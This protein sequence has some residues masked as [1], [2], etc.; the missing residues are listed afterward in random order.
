VRSIRTESICSHLCVSRHSI[1][2]VDLE[3][4]KSSV[5]WLVLTCALLAPM[6]CGSEQGQ[7]LFRP[8][9]DGA[10]GLEISIGAGG[11]GVG[12]TVGATRCSGV[13][14]QDICWHLAETGQSCT[15]AC[16]S[17][18]GTDSRA[19][20]IVG[21]TAQGGDQ[22]N[23]AA[24]LTLLGYRQTVTV[25][26]G[27]DCGCYLYGLGSASYWSSSPDFNPNASRAGARI[28]CGCSS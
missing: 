9:A 23:C 26:S 7:D 17:F 28:A 27:F 16:Q 6:G 8:P 10:G 19:P 12:G 20:G 22:L 14:Y 1:S 21:S 25:V 13:L 11:G 18:G 5:L 24:V 4:V 15:A 3:S 2:V